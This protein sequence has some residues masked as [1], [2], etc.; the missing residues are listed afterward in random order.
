MRKEKRTFLDYL[1]TGNVTPNAMSASILNLIYKK[2]IKVQEISKKGKK[3]VRKEMGN[4][5]KETNGT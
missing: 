2:N 1:M 3:N 5:K 4:K